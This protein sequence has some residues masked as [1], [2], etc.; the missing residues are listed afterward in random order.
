LRHYSAKP[1]D[2]I[3]DIAGSDER[4]FNHCPAYL[5]PDSLYLPVGDMRMSHNRPNFFGMLR[6]VFGRVLQSFWPAFLG[7]VPRKNFMYSGNVNH[8]TMQKLAGLVEMGHVKGLVDSEWAMED[9]IKASGFCLYHVRRK[10]LRMADLFQA[11]QRV[12][13]ARARGQVVVRV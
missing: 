4:I 6:F 9:A 7:G 8:E 11:F 5:K 1:F 2:A 3:I 12:G 10:V 13:T